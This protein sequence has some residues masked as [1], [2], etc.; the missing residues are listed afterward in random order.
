MDSLHSGF[1]K[2][3]QLLTIE[4][5]ELILAISGN[6]DFQRYHND[7][8]KSFIKDEKMHFTCTNNAK[9]KIFDIKT[10]QLIES[11]GRS[12][13]PLFFENGM[14][15][16]QVQPVGDREIHFWHEYEGFRNSIHKFLNTNSL[17]GVL[18]FQN[19]VGYSNFEIRDENNETL[20][21]VVIEIYPTKL[22]YKDDYKALLKEVNEEIYNLAYAFIKRTYLLGTDEV[23]NE[24]TGAEFYRLL[25]KHFNEYIKVV[26]FVEQKPHLELRTVYEEVRGDRLRKQDS[27]GRAYLR[28]N[29]SL[30]IEV[31]NG[32]PIN[33]IQMLPKKGLLIKKE[34]ITDT[35]ENRYVKMTL[36]RLYAR[37]EALYDVIKN[38]KMRFNGEADQEVLFILDDMKSRLSKKLNKPFWRNIGLLDRS[39]ISMVLQMAPGYRDVYQIY[40]TLS[41][42]IVLSGEL[43]K[44]SIKDIATLY[45]YWTFLR[46]GKILREECEQLSQDVIKV[47]SNGLVVNLNKDSGARLVFRNKKTGEIIHLQYQYSTK[48]NITVNQ[49]PDTMLSIKKLGKNYE[50]QYIFDAKY[51]INFGVENKNGPGPM[52]DDINTMHRY[53]D[54]IVAESNGIYERTAFGA[55]VLFPWNEIDRYQEHDLY[56]SIEKVNIGGLP[57]LPKATDL[58]ET[59]I[60]N[61]LNKSA[62]ELQRDGILP[63][64]TKE[65]LY[66]LQQ[67]FV[68]IIPIDKLD[69]IIT[70]RAISVREDQLPI[71]WNNANKIALCTSENILEEGLIKAIERK[72]NY[73]VF[74]VEAWVT[75]LDGI[76][77]DSYILSEPLLVEEY[78]YGDAKSIQELFLTSNEQRQFW[79]ALKAIAN[80]VEI[81]LNR[82]N[83]TQNTS[84]HSFVIPEHEFIW[85]T[86]QLIHIHGDRKEAIDITLLKEN[87]YKVV[88]E[89]VSK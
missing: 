3:V 33:D 77:V 55:Y 73:F 14:Y 38:A 78:L 31:E 45:E 50:Y 85:T 21:S 57:F 39:I 79:L 37:I 46:L 53:R 69:E 56:K 62:E 75:R 51:R 89:L 76:K 48:G 12:F 29:A 32:I 49:K 6:I 80:V 65:F 35:H 26:N 34:H 16:L 86:G 68:M 11:N 63:I 61:L 7:S 64:G 87:P 20:L 41:K 19:E 58:V 74:H 44:M 15:E 42:G 30:F 4:T 84:I 27:K 83:V 5:D 17:T 13:L 1:L 59:I 81:R 40:A 82:E 66:E 54:A 8:S 28:K 72:N 52:E 36:Q 67:E 47:D 71:S 10:N 9:V 88:H 43:Y 24:P 22:N 18:H 70:A 25:Q 60:N 23:Y 2:G